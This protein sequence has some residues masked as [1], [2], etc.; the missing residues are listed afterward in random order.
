MRTNSDDAAHVLTAAVPAEEWAPRGTAAGASRWTRRLIAPLAAA[1]LALASAAAGTGTARATSAG[2]ALLEADAV[3]A[4]HVE[5]AWTAVPGASQYTV[6]RDSNVLSVANTLRVTDTAI[7]AGTAH[8]Y[9]VTATVGGAETGASPARAVSLPAVADTQAP[10]TPGNLHATSVVSS[11]ATLAWQASTDDVGVIGYFLRVGSILYSYTEGSLT[12]NVS[13]LKANTTYTLTLSAMDAAGKQSAPAQVTLTTSPLGT[14][15]TVAPA[16]PSLTATPYSANE[17]D[18]S[19]SKPTDSDLTGFLVF[20]DGQLLED[21]PPNSSVQTRVL[22]VTGLSAQM[23]YTFSVRSYDA[24]GNQS[25]ASAKTV[26]TLAATDVRVTRGP[27]VQRVDTNSARVIWRTNM[28]APSNLSYSDGSRTTT[29]VDAALRTDHSVLIGPLPSLSRITYTLNYPTTQSGNFQTCSSSPAT[30]H[31]DAVGDMG[32]GATPEKDIANLVAGDHPDLIAAMGDDVYPTGLDKDYPARLFVPYAAAMRG[33]AYLTTFGNH[34]YYSPGAA[35]AHRAYSQPGNE[36]YFSFDCSGVHFTVLDAYQPYGPGSTQYQWLANDLAATTQPWKIVVLHVPPYSS[37]TT[38]P[39]PGSAGVLNP[40]FE[41]YHVQLVLAGHSHNYERTNVINGVTY[42]VDGGGGNGINSFSGSP[43]S[44]SAYRA[45]EYSY[46]RLTIT[47]SQL[48][49]TETRQ[50]G[51]TGDT[52]S[53]AGSGTTGV[54]TVIDG[55]P[56]AQTNATTASFAFHSTQTPA[57]F[58]CTL[59]GAATSCASPTTYSGLAEGPHQFSVQA[60]SSTGTDPTPATAG[61]TVDTTPPSAPSGLTAAAPTSA[62]VNLGWTAASDANGIAGYDITRNGFPLTSVSGSTASYSDTTVAAGATYQYQVLARD[63]AGNVSAASNTATVTVPSTAPPVFAD[64]FESGDLSAWTSSSG[65]TVQSA[66]T[67]TGS[68]AAQANTT[69]GATYAKKTLPSGYTDAYSRVFFNLQSM[70]SQVNL[71]RHR[72]A[73]D[74]SIAYVFVNTSGALGI[75]NDTTSTS[76][77]SSTVVAP[78]SGWHE[79]ELHTQINGS[80][81]LLE[82]WLD[83]T[84]ISALSSTANLGTTAIGRLQI[85]DAQTGR[86]YNVVYDDAAFGSQRVGP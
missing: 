73:A 66:L 83:G 8:T 47:P 12:T 37:S 13:Y 34:E 62:A 18:L 45:A 56:P 23:S 81:G 41:Q 30:L 77:T 55:G 3:D 40:L 64:G 24:A 9:T 2:P 74:T 33:S 27:Y 42:M 84:R 78:G 69:T 11:S 79:L 1:A 46:V 52:F 82:V 44:W 85:G 39:Y 86:T 10:T 36:S 29:V 54:D 71:L 58:T 50:N 70:S 5:L 4:G 72:T 7:G 14:S 57:T 26:A 76:L 67:H 28:P 20:Q 6:Y 21:I 51:S 68:F 49:G 48:S 65:M 63:P 25:T 75:R 53:I 16:A 80:S 22:P 15:D 31:L 38:G 60:T 19:W 32:G 35:D 61:W 17:V 43:P 59:D